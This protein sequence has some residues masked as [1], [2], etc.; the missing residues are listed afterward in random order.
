MS[1][2]TP[3]WTPIEGFRRQLG[4]RK[5]PAAAG[6]RQGGHGISMRPAFTSSLKVTDPSCHLILASR[7]Y[8]FGTP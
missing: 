7:S 3:A 5:C 6:L 4:L 2:A 1:E 8:L